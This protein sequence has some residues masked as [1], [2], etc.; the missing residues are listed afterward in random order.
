M[1]QPIEIVGVLIAAGD[2]EDACLEKLRQRV[3]D[4]RRIASVTNGAGKT[5]GNA[6]PAFRLAK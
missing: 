1:A 5:A 3:V 2:G 4:A 6:E